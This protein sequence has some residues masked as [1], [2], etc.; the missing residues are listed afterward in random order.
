[1]GVEPFGSVFTSP[2]GVKQ[3]TLSENR[4][5]SL[6]KRLKNS[7]LSDISRCH[8]RIWR[9]QLIFSS[10]CWVTFALLLFDASLY[11]QWAAIP[12]SAVRCIS[13]VRIWISKGCPFGPIK[14]VCRDWYMFGLGI[15]M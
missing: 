3:Y 11:F 8:S 7:L 5:R 2:A 9:S 1:M 6:F 13:K 14:V 15:A 12:Y 10:S 4:S